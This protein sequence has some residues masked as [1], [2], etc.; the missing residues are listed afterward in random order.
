MLADM[1]RWAEFNAVYLGYFDPD[2]LPARSAFGASG[3]ALGGEVEIEC[4]AY[5]PAE[6]KSLFPEKST[7]SCLAAKTDFD[8][9]KASERGRGSIRRKPS[10]AGTARTRP[11]G[12][13]LAQKPGQPTEKYAFVEGKR[14]LGFCCS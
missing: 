7:F 11:H 13:G 14:I 1:R 10:G 5:W 2:R 8:F 12:A 4:I 9:Q 3:L 6:M